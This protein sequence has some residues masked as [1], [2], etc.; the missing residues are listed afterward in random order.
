MDFQLFQVGK[1]FDCSLETLFLAWTTPEVLNDWWC[2]PGYRCKTLEVDLRPEGAYFFELVPKDGVEGPDCIME[3]RF[4]TVD[5]PN[6]LEY[7]WAIRAADFVE[8]GTTVQVSFEPCEGGTTLNLVHTG[9]S[10]QAS[11]DLHAL[12]WP[13]VLDN[14]EKRLSEKPMLTPA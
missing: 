11:Y 5:A 10:S 12:D 8:A 6:V 13:L 9:F 3:G 7:S 2:T 1:T 14:L 4:I